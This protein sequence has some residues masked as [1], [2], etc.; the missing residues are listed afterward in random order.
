M[1]SLRAKFVVVG[2][3]G[4]SALGLIGL[5]ASAAFTDS[6]SATQIINTGRLAMC[7]S[8]VDGDGNPDGVVSKDCKSVT[9]DLENSGSTI[10]LPHTL[11]ITNT[12][13][14]PLTINSVTVAAQGG[15]LDPA[16]LGDDVR[17]NISGN[18]NYTVRQD[19]SFH[20]VC[21]FCNLKPGDT[22]VFSNNFTA[23]LGNADEGQTIMPTISLGAV[24]WSGAGSQGVPSLAPQK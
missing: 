16:P 22:L 20:W 18:G 24:E 5:G 13:T 21:N 17:W 1:G 23:N 12:G 9:W 8:S 7:I 10:N 15:G 14:L 11:T 3:L 19:E 2:L 4:V 6:V